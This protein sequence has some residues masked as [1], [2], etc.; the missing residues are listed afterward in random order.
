MRRPANPLRLIRPDETLPRA[1]DG[2]EMPIEAQ[3]LLIATV[4]LTVFGMLM[5]YSAS[6]A[7]AMT[8]AAFNH[9]SLYFVKNGLLYTLAGIALMFALVFTPIQ[10]LHL[11]KL[12]PVAFVG[13]TL[14]LV[15]V[16]VPGVGLN[17]NGASRWL[18]IGPVTIQPSEF[19]KF[20]V[21]LMVAAVL[22]SR[23]RPPGTPGELMKPI[24]LL[25]GLVCALIMLQPDLG[26]TLAICIMTLG[27]LVV[28]GVRWRLLGLVVAVG[29]VLVAALIYIEP[30]R[31]DRMLAFLD[32]WGQS[33]DGAYQVVQAMIA[34][35]SGGIFGV[36]L[37]GSV[38]KVNFLP[39]AHTDMIF[40]VI[41]EELGLIGAV[42][43]VGLF[44]A[45][46][47]S[48]Y[49]IAMRTKDPFLRLVAAGATALI[50]GQAVVNLGAVMGA[51]PLTG[52]PLPLISYGSSSRI[53]ILTLI[54]I[55]IAIARE[56]QVLAR[57]APAGDAA[58]T[59]RTRRAPARR[60]AP[61]TV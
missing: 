44:A 12:A 43:V 57:P 54:G 29:V 14:L 1:G 30:Y 56:P 26:T 58:G 41:G 20:G 42:L 22:A 38:Q 25:V 2:R 48:G 9:D 46:A 16:I 23:K 59:R 35:G 18:A 10:R 40:A 3:V 15:A 28:A 7:H 24:G 19:A 13:S 39:E 5:V 4:I 61:E 6:S 51:L 31:R 8:N 34:I 45:V 50:V 32:P 55:L 21:L 60:N 52:I 36:G 17:I 53:V 33:A 49:T 47:W 27:L 11:R 37:G